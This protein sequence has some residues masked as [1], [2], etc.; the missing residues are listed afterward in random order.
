[1]RQEY[2]KRGWPVRLFAAPLVLALC[3]ALAGTAPALDIAV[4]DTGGPSACGWG[5]EES[6]IPCPG[7]QPLPSKR[8]F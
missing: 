3:L 5:P 7:A 8:T 6:R 2:L 1:M 4:T